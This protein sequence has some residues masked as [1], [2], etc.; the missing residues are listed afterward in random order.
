MISYNKRNFATKNPSKNSQTHELIN[1]NPMKKL[2]AFAAVVA[3]ISLGACTGG[4]NANTAEEDS[5][6]LDN[7]EAVVAVS[8]LTES[9]KDGDDAAISEALDN[10]G[11]GLQAALENGEKEKAEVYLN[12]IK[13]FLQENTDQIKEMSEDNFTKLADIINNAIA[14]IPTDAEAAVEDAAA[15]VEADAVAAKD[16]AVNQ[17][18]Q[19]A[20][21]AQNKANEAMQDAVN[22]V[23]QAVQN[24]QDQANQ[25]MQD[26]AK[27]ANQAVSDAI[28][29]A[30]KQITQ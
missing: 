28:N 1:S 6:A 2:F 24:A 3:A 9:V 13:T 7:P 18:N 14:K 16:A 15:A 8:V 25:A 17:A 5:L 20:Q 4:T 12:E 10:I 27:K 30:M 11:A 26:A 19:A 23:N 29:E 22:Q 21:D